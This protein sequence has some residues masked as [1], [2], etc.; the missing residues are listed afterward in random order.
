MENGIGE[1]LEKSLA[2]WKLIEIRSSSNYRTFSS[3]VPSNLVKRI[4]R[5]FRRKVRAEIRGTLKELLQPSEIVSIHH[6][7]IQILTQGCTKILN[8]I[9]FFL[10]L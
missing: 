8:C 4:N 5:K 3:R 9:T 6:K 7:N 2:H 1:I 10:Q